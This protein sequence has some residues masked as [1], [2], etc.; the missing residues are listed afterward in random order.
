MINLF[1]NLFIIAIPLI[2]LRSH[3]PILNSEANG[4]S[5][6]LEFRIGI[7]VVAQV[8]S[9]YVRHSIRTVDL[10]CFRT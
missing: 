8:I 3:Q 7:A 10:G 4:S 9:G 6:D 1:E 2:F 5:L